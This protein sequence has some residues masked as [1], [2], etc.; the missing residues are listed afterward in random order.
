M[1]RSLARK[2]RPCCRKK[3]ITHKRRVRS[4]TRRR[5]KRPTRRRARQRRRTRKARRGGGPFGDA[6]KRVVRRTRTAGAEA[7]DA[8]TKAAATATA[9]VTNAASKAQDTAD[10]ALFTGAAKGHIRRDEAKRVVAQRE[11]GPSQEAKYDALEMAKSREGSKNRKKEAFLELLQKREQKTLTKEEKAEIQDQIEGMVIDPNS[12]E[13]SFDQQLK[14]NTAD[15]TR[16]RYAPIM[17]RAAASPGGVSGAEG[18]A[19]LEKY[20]LLSEHG[21][22]KVGPDGEPLVL[23]NG[24]YHSSRKRVV[25][26]CTELTGSFPKS[27]IIYALCQD[28]GKP[29]VAGYKAGLAIL[30]ESADVPSTTEKQCYKFRKD[31]KRYKKGMFSGCAISP[32]GCFDALE[33]Y[34]L[35]YAEVFMTGWEKERSENTDKGP[36]AKDLED[37]KAGMVEA[38]Q[39]ALNGERFGDDQQQKQNLILKLTAKFDL[40]GGKR[41]KLNEWGEKKSEY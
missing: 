4:R 9:T 7:T 15:W 22:P 3:S 27:L 35:G 8:I 23:Y 10:V 14:Y 13:K 24:P 41:R 19:L 25:G 40:S 34:S 12:T 30:C 36:F 18:K 20:D 33:E 39:A 26:D 5:T 31:G 21:S 28:E 11:Q 37:H 38:T 2:R 1:P 6:F 29:S 17:A 32:K 16:E